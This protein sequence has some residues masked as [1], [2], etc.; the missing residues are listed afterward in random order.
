MHLQLL[1]GNRAVSTMV[2]QRAPFAFAQRQKHPGT[3][4]RSAFA[5][6]VFEQLEKRNVTAD[7]GALFLLNGQN[8]PGLMAAVDQ[9]AP[10]RE[11][12]LVGATGPNPFDGPRL[13]TAFQASMSG[14]S[15]DGVAALELLDAYRSYGDDVTGFWRDKVGPI[16]AKRLEQLLLVYDRRVLDSFKRYLEH[17]PPKVAMKVGPIL[18]K[19]FDPDPKDIELEFRPDQFVVAVTIRY[20]DG[21]DGPAQWPMGVMIARVKGRVAAMIT[22]RGGP[23]ESRV[24]KSG[25]RA[26][27][28]KPGTYKLGKG[29]PVVGPFWDA[30]QIRWGAEVRTVAGPTGPEVE[31]RTD[32]GKW[33]NTLKLKKP[34]S[35][36]LILDWQKILGRPPLVPSSWTLNP[37]G[38]RGY[39]VGDTDVFIHTTQPNED[40]YNGKLEEQ[41]DFSHGCIHIKPS[42]RDRLESMKLLKAGATVIIRPYRRGV[43]EYG[44]P[45]ER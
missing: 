4:A 35:R 45:P 34:I 33:V 28:S 13:A 17:A 36:A 22:A 37:F 44:K 15:A 30:A 2:A 25:H 31:Y 20:P 9:V 29:A 21:H 6:S 24:E 27:P 7:G 32:S 43:K 23:W 8:P 16:S 14:K 11:L 12:G 42:D 10:L 19:L 38:P 26:D 5:Q 40:Q 39:Q 18:G 41:L 3:V 1:A